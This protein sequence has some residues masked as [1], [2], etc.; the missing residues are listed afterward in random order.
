MNQHERLIQR[1]MDLQREITQ[2]KLT[3]R[4]LFE[5]GH[6]QR[7]Y[8]H[9]IADPWVEPAGGL[10]CQQYQQRQRLPSSGQGH[11]QPSY[12]SLAGGTAP[13]GGKANLHGQRSGQ[14]LLR[15]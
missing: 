4:D 9:V 15:A 2:A 11:H 7:R 12:P 13:S 10:C 5:N 8:R 3:R 1:T 6:A 14:Y